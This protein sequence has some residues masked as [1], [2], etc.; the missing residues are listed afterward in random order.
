MLFTQAWSKEGGR[1]YFSNALGAAAQI[2]PW[3]MEISLV[4]M[5]PVSPQ[6]FQLGADFVCFGK[7]L[8]VVNIIALRCTNQMAVKAAGGIITGPMPDSHALRKVALVVQ[9]EHEPMGA[10]WSSSEPIHAVA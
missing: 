7:Q 9:D 4:R 6:C 8:D 1:G 10:L 2:V 5:L 3:V